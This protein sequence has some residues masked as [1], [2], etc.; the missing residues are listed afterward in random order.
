MSI[1]IKQVIHNGAPCD[2]FIEGNR[3][4]KIAP[5]IDCAADQILDGHHKAILPAFYNTHNHAAMTSMRGYADDI[6]LFPWL[7]N[8]IWPFEACITSDDV[9]HCT[10]LAILEMIRGGTVFFNDMY[11]FSTS[12]LRAVEEMGL[13]A[14]I[15]HLF[16]ETSPGVIHEGNLREN[17]ALEAMRKKASSRITVTYAPHAIYTVSGKTLCH[18]AEKAKAE[19]GFIHIHA[20]ET[21]WE[22]SN[23]HKEHG[24]SPIAWLDRCGMLGPKTILAHCVHLSVEDIALIH[25]RG[26]IIAHNPI[27][28]LK[29]ASGRFRFQEVIEESKC[30]ITL[31]TDGVASN[32]NLSMLDTM[33]FAALSAKDQS[34]KATVAPAHVIFDAATIKGAEA[35]GIQAGAI[36]EG[37]L[38]DAIL[39]DLCQPSMVPR[40]HL[41][42]NIVYA[43]D[44]ACIDTLICDGRL[45]MHNRII[46]GEQEIIEAAQCS[47]AGILERLNQ[48][49]GKRK[50]L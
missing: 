16:I 17:E 7:K 39:V 6:D 22:V 30:K 47:I 1:L 27:S 12:T 19:N 20:S 5:S 36:A 37:R 44:T 13:R 8:H 48:E 28:N 14:A 45:L 11:W 4:K 21:E 46:P 34:R 3:F 31:G 41:I 32:N 23:S 24:M 18:V 38:A 10:R 42:S 49:H 35:F 2:V 15:G 29:L 43:A 40:H 9:Y 33:K 26:C 25:E 50:G